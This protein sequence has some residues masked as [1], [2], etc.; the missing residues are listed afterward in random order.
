MD[1]ASSS[2]IRMSSESKSTRLLKRCSDSR[3]AVNSPLEHRRS[4]HNRRFHN[5]PA[6]WKVGDP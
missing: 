5:A 3:C 4:S 2:S 6:R 1:S